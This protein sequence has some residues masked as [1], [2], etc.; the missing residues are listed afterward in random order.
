MYPDEEEIKAIKKIHSHAEILE[1][2]QVIK[3][4]CDKNSCDKCPFSNVYDSGC[5]IQAE[6][7]EDWPI[8]TEEE[9]WRAFGN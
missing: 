2:L 4:T 7:P 9:N 6:P 3:D 8:K 5:M 1:A